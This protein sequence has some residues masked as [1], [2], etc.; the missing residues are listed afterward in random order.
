MFLVL[1]QATKTS[2]TERMRGEIPEKAGC[3]GW[4]RLSTGAGKPVDVC[5]PPALSSFASERGGG[6]GHEIVDKLPGYRQVVHRA[7]L[8]ARE[9]GWYTS[10]RPEEGPVKRTYQPKRRRRKRVHGYRARMASPGG[11]NV[12]RRRR[13]AGRK[14]L[15]V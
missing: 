3:A 14:R 5:G 13:Q 11:R 7:T 1:R 4:G 10:P 15:T 8:A 6:P 9:E 2:A 12:L